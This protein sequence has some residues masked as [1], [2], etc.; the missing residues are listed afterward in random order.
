LEVFSCQWLTLMALVDAIGQSNG[1]AIEALIE[2][3]K[4][5]S[6]P[7]VALFSPHIRPEGVFFSLFAALNGMQM[8]RT[9]FA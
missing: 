6:S 9:R 5:R 8:R 7:I 4:I 3:Y 2:Q 1:E